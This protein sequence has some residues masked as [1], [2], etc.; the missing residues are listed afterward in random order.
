MHE[1]L[2]G[3]WH[4]GAFDI[5]NSAFFQLESAAFNLRS[6]MCDTEH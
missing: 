6:S 4:L 5:D 1:L 2:A 3:Q